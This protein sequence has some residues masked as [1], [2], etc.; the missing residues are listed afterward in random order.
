MTAPPNSFRPFF[1]NRHNHLTEPGSNPQNEFQK[2]NF[3]AVDGTG[4]GD[5]FKVEGTLHSHLDAPPVCL[6]VWMNLETCLLMSLWGAFAWLLEF[7]IRFIQSF[8][9]YKSMI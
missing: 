9:K 1:R 3:K 6:A 4:K 2:T 8:Q 7:V 5:Q